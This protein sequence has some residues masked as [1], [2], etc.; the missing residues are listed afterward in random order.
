MTKSLRIL[1]QWKYMN[2]REQ[3]INGWEWGWGNAVMHA[4]REKGLRSKN[5]RYAHLISNL[6]YS[7]L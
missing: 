3:I 1:R 5:F 4:K 6:G 7:L 2:R